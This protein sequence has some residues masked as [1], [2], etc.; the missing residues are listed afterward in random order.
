[1]SA[2]TTILRR[3]QI[4]F[5][6][7]CLLAVSVIG[8]VVWLQSTQGQKYNE[9]ALAQIRHQDIP[10]MRGNLYADDGSLLTSD[11]PI[12]DLRF[13][14]KTPELSEAQF[15][16]SAKAFANQLAAYLEETEG[17]QDFLS[18]RELY[19]RI[20]EA[21][22]YA[23][24]ISKGESVKKKS[25]YRNVLIARQLTYEQRKQILAMPLVRMGR[26]KSGMRFEEKYTR[27]FPYAELA[28]RT[29]GY[30]NNASSQ[31][32]LE[33]T[34]NGYLKGEAGVRIVYRYAGGA[35]VP[36]ADSSARQREPREGRD[37]HTTLNVNMQDV[38]N[39]ALIKA[40]VENNAT[41]GCAVLMEV[42]TGK[43][44]AIANL[45]RSADGTY[46]EKFNYA[47]GMKTE[48]G[49]T[50]K[51]ASAIV[52]IEAGAYTPETMVDI[53][54]GI[55]QF[56]GQKMED[57]HKGGL[58]NITLTKAFAKSSNVGIA[59]LTVKAF[60]RKPSSFIDGLRKLHVGEP[61]HLQLD[62]ENTKTA[63][64]PS[65]NS[66]GWSRIS[67]PWMSIGYG[68]AVTPLQTLTL[69]NAIAN[70]GKMVKPY[71]VSEIRELG[72]TV[73][74]FDTE[75][76]DESICSRETA[77]MMT[78]MLEEVVRHGTAHSINNPYF[79]IAGKTGTT[80]I[81]DDNRGYG[82]DGRI[83]HQSSFVGFFPAEAP[84]YSCIVVI[85]DPKGFKYT[86][87]DVAA[88][89]FQDIANHVYATLLDVQPL[90][91]DS[92]KAGRAKLLVKPGHGPDMQRSLEA[93]GIPYNDPDEAEWVA[94]SVAM[95]DSVLLRRRVYKKGQVPDVTGMGLS[96]AVYLLEARGLRVRIQGRGR[97]IQQSLNPGE[98]A[99]YK[100]SITLTL[101]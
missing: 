87:A 73:K 62:G 66:P 98:K 101:S 6:L 18:S 42:A 33:R 13:D 47:I 48:P 96:D 97:V 45:T 70:G 22:R 51:L 21:Y 41:Y 7:L 53:E 52:G 14:A 72:Q 15:A 77:Q 19:S 32:G 67:L 59:K 55:T 79:R 65:P 30:Y 80:Q 17:A 24:A 89:V 31:V 44:K 36:V 5:G 1:M 85:S 90:R 61:L 49:S 26:Y 11:V 50:F 88:P 20:M 54:G 60:G 8:R 100:K 43:V 38:A 37:V 83:S 78:E 91:G 82:K 2:K 4:A 71:F 95:G 27:V 9:M 75:V 29:L 46:S 56:P 93:V 81:A 39:R 68:I 84:R 74:R 58:R 10:A 23:Q 94:P 40:L 92:D 34:F 28:R 16:D 25:G 64:I 69:Y 63:Y 86:G 99:T 76:I 35:Y 3:L 12:Y 57:S